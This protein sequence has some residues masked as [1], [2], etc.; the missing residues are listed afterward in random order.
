MI[1]ERYWQDGILEVE[2]GEHDPHRDTCR[3]CRR[4]HEARA[5]LIKALPRV[6][7]SCSGD[8]SWQTQVWSRITRE[9][10]KRARR[11]YWLAGGLA[12]ACALAV[13]WLLAMHRETGSSSLQMASAGSGDRPRIDIMSGTLALRSTSA[14]VGDRVRISVPHGGEVRIYRADRLVLRC[15]A[16]QR[17]ASCTLDRAGL[18]AEAELATPGE[19]RL[20]LIPSLTAAPVGT[21]DDDLAAVVA[22]GG[23]YKLTEL[24]VR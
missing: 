11:S 12:A 23:N 10:T 6:G 7:A 17:S 22:F 15:P 5:E 2:R 8:P 21:L 1:C 16:W 24:S 9:E 14:R 13:V 20:V 4:A 3:D 18:V 19:Y